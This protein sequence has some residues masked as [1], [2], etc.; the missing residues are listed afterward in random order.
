M[1]ADFTLTAEA[2]TDVGKGA[3]RRLRRL[4]NRVPAII[5]GDE[6]DPE[7]ISLLHKDLMKQLEN[8]AF[9]SHIITIDTGGKK[10]EV[11]LKDLQRHP[12]KVKVLHA[13]FLRVSRTKKLHTKVPLHFLNETTCVGV[14]QHGGSIAH[15]MT[16]LE[17]SCLPQDLPEYL[18]VDL[19]LV[20][21]GQIVHISDFTLPNGVESVSVAHGA[22]HDL[23]GATVNKPRAGGDEEET[24]AP[25]AGEA[26][27]EGGE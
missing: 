2:R 13:D 19:A 15:N 5:Y 10:Q 25:A 23:P 8:E 16:D 21:I 24:S 9:Y 11:I 4:S 14:K 18:E 20:E 27:A 3:S 6:K 17:L 1:S 7:N 22:D 12:A 26:P